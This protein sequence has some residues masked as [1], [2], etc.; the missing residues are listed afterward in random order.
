M[1]NKTLFKNLSLLGLFVTGIVLAPGIALADRG[2]RDHSREKYSNDDRRSHSNHNNYRS[3]GKRHQGYERYGSVR[4]QS[5]GHGRHKN[6]AHYK[7]R[8]DGRRHGYYTTYIV[9]DRYYANDFYMPNPFRFI[10]GLHTNNIDIIL[11][12]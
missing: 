10:I 12:D 8:Y 5:R 6:Q 4:N 7:H 9:N 3:Y 2:E 1:N 11:R